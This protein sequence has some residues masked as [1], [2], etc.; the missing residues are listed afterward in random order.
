MQ[1]FLRYTK[2]LGDSNLQDFLKDEFQNTRKLSIPLLVV[3][4]RCYLI[5][6][7]FFTT[8]FTLK[9]VTKFHGSLLLFRCFE[10][11]QEKNVSMSIF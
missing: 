7:S 9:K 5:A 11:R 10:Y 3:P 6:G 2:R 4:L 1:D 8:C